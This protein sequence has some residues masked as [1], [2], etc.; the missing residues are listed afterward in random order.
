MAAGGTRVGGWVVGGGYWAGRKIYH[1]NPAR[2]TFQFPAALNPT[3]LLSDPDLDPPLH[4][5]LRI[6]AQAHCIRPDLQDTT[7][8]D[9]EETW[10][11]D[12]RSFMLD[13]QQLVPP[14]K[15]YR[16]SPYPQG[17]LLRKQN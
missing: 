6:P 14:W 3:M 10:F 1:Y 15:P 5:C 7:L 2:I 8:P 11:M 17:H 9:T 12:G 16:L 13:G 4:D